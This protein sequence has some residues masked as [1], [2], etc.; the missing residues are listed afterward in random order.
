VSRPVKLKMT[1]GLK[2]NSIVRLSLGDSAGCVVADDGRAYCWGS[3]AAGQLGSPGGDTN[4]PRAV[5]ASGALSGQFLER[6]STGGSHACVVSSAGGVYCWGANDKGQ[7]GTGKAGQGSDV[8]VAVDTSGV[9]AGKR[10]TRV[11]ATGATTCAADSDGQMYCWGDNSNGQFGNGSTKDSATPVAVETSTGLGD[12][13]VTSMSVG[14]DHTCAIVS[15]GTAYCW[16]RNDHGQLGNGKSDSSATPVNVVAKKSD[17]I[18]AFVHVGVG[19]TTTCAIGDD[20]SGWC[21]GSNANGQLGAGLEVPG[22]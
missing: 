15:E 6:L 20:G 14:D 19:D 8:P 1:D 2:G 3:N 12:A 22:Q 4:V 13:K 9:L 10:I 7:L 17:P 11:G 16:G 21:W 18:P 5:D